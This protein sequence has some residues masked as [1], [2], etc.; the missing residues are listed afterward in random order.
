MT[1]VKRTAVVLL[2]ATFVVLGSFVWKN[3]L[4]GVLGP[5]S[6]GFDGRGGQPF[7]DGDRGRFGPPPDGGDRG[8]RRGRGDGDRGGGN[9]GQWF[10]A[11]GLEGFGHVFMPLMIAGAVIIGFDVANRRR[12]RRGG[13][14]AI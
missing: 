2:A 14:T 5:S 9:S 12:K 11:R 8:E 4:T 13:P 7:G 1:Y 6:T 3:H 10:S